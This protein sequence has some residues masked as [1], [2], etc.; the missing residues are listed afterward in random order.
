M[1]KVCKFYKQKKQVSFDHVTWQDVIPYQYRKGDLYEA[2]S[3]DCGF[4]LMYNW[5]LSQGDY[6]CDGVRK[7]NVEV[8]QYS[9]DGSEFINVEPEYKR[10]VGDV[11]D[12]LSEDCG[13]VESTGAFKFSGSS[14]IECGSHYSNY[15]EQLLT[16]EEVSGK[17]ATHSVVGDC[18]EIIG[19]S[20]FADTILESIEISDYVKEIDNGAFRDCTGLTYVRIPDSVETFGVDVV[21]DSE[22]FLHCSNLTG[23]TLPSGLD[24]I[25]PR[26]F[27]QSGLS[28]YVLPNGIREIGDR[29]F[30]GLSGF[31]I[32]FNEVITDLGDN[33]FFDT[34]FQGGL[35]LPS[36]LKSI[37]LWD[38]AVTFDGNLVLPEGLEQIGGSFLCDPNLPYTPVKDYGEVVIPSSVK[39]FQG[40]S[41]SNKVSFILNEGVEVAYATP[42]NGLPNSVLFTAP[43]CGYIPFGCEFNLRRE[44]E[45]T[46]RVKGEVIIPENVVVCNGEFPC[47][48]IITVNPPIPPIDVDFIDNDLWCTLYIFVPDGSVELYKLMWPK[49]SNKIRPLSMK[50]YEWRQ[51]DISEEYECVGFDKH[52]KEHKFISLDNGVNWYDTCISRAGELYERNSIDCGYV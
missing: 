10:K 49:V 39:V 34:T 22:L 50:K 1:A 30:I 40:G 25:P 23:V 16:R 48:A 37:G 18:T 36:S 51:I 28:N 52:Y 44:G 29:A 19:A 9:V 11:V 26:M 12:Y 46:V 20:A 5:A 7:Y 4:V 24:Y 47:N 14:V 2:L 35:T 31:N 33:V 41:D 21:S 6:E 15:S 42:K 45:V 43:G 17:V 27:Q 38:N 13:Y 3:S 8:L 32:T